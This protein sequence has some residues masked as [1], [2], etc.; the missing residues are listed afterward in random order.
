MPFIELNGMAKARTFLNPLRLM[1]LHAC[2][3]HRTLSYTQHSH[4]WASSILLSSMPML[5]DNIEYFPF[6]SFFFNRAWKYK[7]RESLLL[8]ATS[9]NQLLRV[10][11][12]LK[13]EKKINQ[14]KQSGKNVEKAPCCL[15]FT[16]IYT[17]IRHVTTR[18]LCAIYVL[19]HKKGNIRLHD[20]YMQYVRH[21]YLPQLH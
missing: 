13:F 2:C 11:I 19:V 14:E 7:L 10:Q 6:K 21:I 8:S 16:V 20:G 5:L 12:H 3:S 4:S 17:R 15:H 18:S 1:S 9:S